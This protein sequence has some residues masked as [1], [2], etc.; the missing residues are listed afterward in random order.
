MIVAIERISTIIPATD[1]PAT[2]DA[3]LAAIRAA[4]E[5]PEEIIV[6]DEPAGRG[7]A[8]TRNDGAQQSSGEILVFVD[9][10]VE[11]HA[12]AFTRIRRAFEAEPDLA[13][14]FG[15]YDDDPRAGGIVSD[16]RNL[17]HHHVHHAGAGPAAT[18]WAGL[19]AVRRDAF[20]DVGGFDESR[21]PR[22]SIE[23]IDLG[24]RLHAAGRR[25]TLD[26]RIQGTHL[27]R[28]TLRTM[29][30]TDLLG[31]G[32]PWVELILS[33]RA[34]ATALNLGWRHRSS[35]LASLILI[36]SIARR[37]PCG[38]LLG[39][40]TLGALNWSFYR[41]LLH[42]RGRLHAAV[43]VALHAVHHVCAAAAVPLGV[44]AHLRRRLGDRR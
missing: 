44:L 19:G 40:V 5:P 3:A 12:D 38:T 41:L 27:K 14:I 23:D 2:L 30:Q 37:R 33:R 25:I 21:F 31:R 13:A 18:F 9:S 35:T 43:G 20:V 36:G 17:L 22:A 1:R 4:A 7:P 15:S 10:D 26:P 24:A 16:F 32:V 42:R 39:L 28:W 34:D 29:V 8:G 6:V 11:V